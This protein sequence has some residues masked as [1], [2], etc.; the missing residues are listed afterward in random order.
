MQRAVIAL[1]AVLALS[2][3]GCETATP[4]QPLTPGSAVS[5][6]FS[7][8][9]LDENHYRVTFRGNDMTSRERVDGYLLYRAAELTVNNGFDWFE[10][11][12]S[13]THNNGGAFVE[14]FAPGPWGG[15]WAPYW[16]F[17]GWGWG[18]GWGPYGGGPYWGGYDVER[19][20]QYD[21][22]AEI[23]MYHGPKPASDPRAL[24]ARQVLTNLGP[25]I[26]RPH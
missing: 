19:V 16:S 20:N 25:K 22:V 9:R 14:P 13:H 17:G 4:Y 1:A 7:D 6:G 10:M 11:V 12:D 5:G 21:A 26:V 15:Y 23:A 18:G 2:L 8:Q 24:D 3:A